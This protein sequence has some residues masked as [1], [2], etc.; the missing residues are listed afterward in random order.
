MEALEIFEID[1]IEHSQ[2]LHWTQ[3]PTRNEAFIVTNATYY[4]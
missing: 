3:N 4:L 1:F 2:T